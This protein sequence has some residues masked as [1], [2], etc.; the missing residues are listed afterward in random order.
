MANLNE[1]T[2]KKVFT[3]MYHGLRDESKCSECRTWTKIDELK[4]WDGMCYS[5]YDRKL[6]RKEET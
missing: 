1:N 4:K 3:Y 2:D 5:C 6:N